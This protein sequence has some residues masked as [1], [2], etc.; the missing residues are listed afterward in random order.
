MILARRAGDAN[1]APIFF[2][3]DAGLI[4]AIKPA[5]EIIESMVAEAEEIIKVRLNR[6]LQKSL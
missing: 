4:D 1:N 6:L 3:Q 5:A 2:G